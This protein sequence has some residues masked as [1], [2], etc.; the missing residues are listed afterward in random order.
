ME[1]SDDYEKRS[2]HLKNLTEE[3]LEKR[4]WELADQITSPLIKL[5]QTHTS[6][7]IERSVLLR[8]GFSSIESASIVKQASDKLLLG[9]G[10]GHI[11]Y[12]V[13][14]VTGKQV[15]EAGAALAEGVGWEDAEKYFRERGMK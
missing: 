11:V 3:Q 2:E 14:L 4:F 13:S 12:A 15:Y 6:P 10:A 5:A 8:M 9:K 1:R 7:S